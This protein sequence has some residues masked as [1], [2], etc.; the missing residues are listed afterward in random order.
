MGLR[1]YRFVAEFLVFLGAWTSAHPWWIVPGVLGAFITA[2][3]VLRAVRTIFLGPAPAGEAALRDARG[4]E[5]LSFVILSGALVV[6]GVWPRAILGPL[7]AG[8]AELLSR[9]SN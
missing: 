1:A 3:Y 4:V 2:L 7:N 8:V 9:I 6:L 5:W